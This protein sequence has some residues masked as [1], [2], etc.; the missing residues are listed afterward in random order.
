MLNVI[1]KI[2]NSEK[3]QEKHGKYLKKRGKQT[4]EHEET[5]DEIVTTYQELLL[6]EF[7]SHLVTGFKAFHKLLDLPANDC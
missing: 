4:V 6:G 5:Y 2:E 3:H 1:S 7:L